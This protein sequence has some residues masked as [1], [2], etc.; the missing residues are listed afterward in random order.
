[1]CPFTGL[2]P[3]LAKSPVFDHGCIVKPGQC[4][5]LGEVTDVLASLIPDDEAG[6]KIMGHAIQ[7]AVLLI[8]N[9]E[10]KL[11][12]KCPVNYTWIFNTG[13]HGKPVFEPQSA[14]VS[15]KPCDR[16]RAT[17]YVIK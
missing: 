11:G 7:Q 12:V 13:K 2:K 4:K 5:T 14:I 16:V 15:M 3:E 8:Y 17:I 9:E 1:M 10:K 6:K